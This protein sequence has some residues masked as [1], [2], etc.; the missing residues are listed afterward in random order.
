VRERYDRADWRQ[1]C[2]KAVLD[3]EAM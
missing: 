2:G 3:A 1:H